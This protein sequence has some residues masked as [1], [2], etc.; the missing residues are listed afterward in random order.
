MPKN[1]GQIQVEFLKG[2]LAAGGVIVKANFSIERGLTSKDPIIHL[3]LRQ[4]GS[5]SLQEFPWTPELESFLLIDRPV[6][7]E[8]EEEEIERLGNVLSN[9]LKTAEDAFGKD[10][11]QAVFVELIHEQKQY[12]LEQVLRKVATHSPHMSGPEYTRCRDLLSNAIVGLQNTAVLSL[13]YPNGPETIKLIGQA[14]GIVLDDRFHITL[15]K[16]LFPE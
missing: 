4:N 7:M 9:N 3:T 10:Y 8:T 12:G 5:L 6:R 15:R 11:A 2:F 13:K 16:Q 14:L 1:R